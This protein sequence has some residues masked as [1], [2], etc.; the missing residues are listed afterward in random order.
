MTSAEGAESAEHPAETSSPHPPALSRLGRAY[1]RR[2]RSPR[3]NKARDLLRILLNRHDMSAEIA[4][5]AERTQLNIF[6][7][8]S[9]PS[10]TLG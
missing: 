6:S 7:A 2:S 1:P 8:S 4:E 3:S 5:I 9:G 10:Q